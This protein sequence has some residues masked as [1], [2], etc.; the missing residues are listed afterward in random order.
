MRRSK[1]LMAALSQHCRPRARATTGDRRADP[2]AAAGN[3]AAV[4][5]LRLLFL[6]DSRTRLDGMRVAAV[7]GD[8]DT[9]AR[10]AHALI[11]SARMVGAER[12]SGACQALETAARTDGEAA[13]TLPALRDVETAF[14]RLR[15]RFEG[16]TCR[17]AN[18]RAPIDADQPAAPGT[19]SA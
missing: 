10:E 13:D 4:D 16:D 5:R 8:L 2:P 11:G 7:D 14:E 18:R 6:E 17:P 19:V 3:P 1:Q 9:V 15:N 12:M